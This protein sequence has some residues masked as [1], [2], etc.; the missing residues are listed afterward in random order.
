[1]IANEISNPIFNYKTGE[2]EDLLH[3]R[4]DTCE[5]VC[6]LMCQKLNVPPVVQLLLGLRINGTKL[7]LAG[8]RQLLDGEKYE[9]RIRFKVSYKSFLLN[10]IYSIS[11]FTDPEAF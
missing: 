3:D 10:K 5:N 6:K 7:W 11:L 2:F 1:M 9:F 8:C 4:A